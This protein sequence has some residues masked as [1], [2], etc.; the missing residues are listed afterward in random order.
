MPHDFTQ[1]SIYHLCACA[2]ALTQAL[3][4]ASQCVLCCIGVSQMNIGVILS[5][6]NQRY[7][8]DKLSIICEFVPQMIFLNGLFGYL[9]I[10]I[11]A[12]WI[13][14]SEADLYHIMIYMFL[15]P[16][17]VDCSTTTDGVTTAGCP[18]NKMFAGQAGFQVIPHVLLFTIL[19]LCKILTL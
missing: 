19:S 7:F 18:R 13:S 6:F 10:L 11:V 16:G 12:K 17:N 2:Q 1:E 4:R 5:L 9:C 14:G 15:Q 3:A 8:R